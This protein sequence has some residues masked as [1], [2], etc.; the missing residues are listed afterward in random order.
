VA[1]FIFHSLPCWSMVN[2]FCLSVFY[3][4]IAVYPDLQ[5]YKGPVDISVYVSSCL[6][7]MLSMLKMYIVFFR[8]I[9]LLSKSYS[10]TGCDDLEK[11]GMDREFHSFSILNKVH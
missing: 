5:P 3:R 1:L 8:H 6:F 9:P 7:M 2:L 11:P 4:A 10:L